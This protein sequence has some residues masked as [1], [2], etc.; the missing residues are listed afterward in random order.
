MDANCTVREFLTAKNATTT[1]CGAEARDK[2]STVIWVAA[3][4]CA[5]AY[6]SIFLR[7]YTRH[8][9]TQGG[10]FGWDDYSTMVTAVFLAPL[11]AG[12]ILLAKN[13]L[14]KDIWTLP[15]HSIDATLYIFYIQEHLYIICTVLVKLSLLLFYFRIFPDAMFRK[16]V[17]ATLIF[18]LCFGVSALFA[19]AFQCTPIDRSWH[20]WDDEHPGTCVNINALVLTAAALNICADFWIIVLPIPGIVSLQSSIRMRIQISAMFC[21]GFL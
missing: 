6:T 2:R 12:A 8:F 19:F 17:G 5:L 21:T 15:F 11:T 1:T 14:G 3:I 16:V 20:G 4:G 13:G 10:E 9:V 7:L 18:A